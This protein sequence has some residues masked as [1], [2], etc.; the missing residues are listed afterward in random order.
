MAGKE[1]WMEKHQDTEGE[2]EKVMDTNT[3]GSPGYQ[4]QSQ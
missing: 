2:G 3:G 1:E 4:S